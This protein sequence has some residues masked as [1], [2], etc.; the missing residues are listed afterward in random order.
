MIKR[1]LL[2]PGPTPVPPEVLLAMARPMIHHRAPEF[3]KLFAE[4]RDGLKWLFQTQSDV[5]MLASSG[6][7][8]MEGAV[9]NFLS[10]GDKAL[11]V[12]G[13][14]FG[15]RWGKLCKAFGA[16]VTEL[17]VEWGR[18]VD[19]QAVS[20]ALKK[21]PAIKAVYVQASETSTGVAHDVQALAKIVKA[22][23]ETILVVDA[24]TAL[25]V[26]DI[27]TDEWGIDVVVTGSQKALMLPPGLAFVSVS[28]KAWQLADKA[29]NTSFYFNFKR[30]RD[31]QQKNQT[32]YTPA[33][34]LIIGL[35]E[36]LK[37]L[38]A[39]GLSAVFNRQANLAKAMRE[40]MQAAGLALFPKESPSDALT[41]ISAPEGVDGQAIYKNLRTQYGITAA[42]GQDHLKGK[43]F[44]LSH[45]GYMDR[46]DVIVA[47]AAT[48]MVIKGLGHPIKLGSGVAKAQEILMAK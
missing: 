26:F 45:M 47:M 29:K 22:H 30:E 43:I 41:A 31:N 8:G 10:P 33:V 16:Q 17:K 18:A 28:E 5:L 15:E 27:K 24:I 40:G 44:R 37:M 20:D 23:G 42:G 46:F 4:V 9:S 12:N 3:D 39:E 21:D 1:Y 19:P 14:K 11:T 36:V 38:K 13:G 48:E 6:T 2:A 25:G 34:S 35:Q 7:G 32:A